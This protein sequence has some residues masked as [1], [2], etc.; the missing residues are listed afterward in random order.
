MSFIIFRRE[1][2]GLL[3]DIAATSVE[4]ALE[5]YQKMHRPPFAAHFYAHD[6]FSVSRP[7]MQDYRI[8]LTMQ[9]SLSEVL[10]LELAER[11]LYDNV[12]MQFCMH[13]AF[14]TASKARMM[15][16]NVSRYL[17]RG[18]VFIGTIPDSSLLLWVHIFFC[19]ATVANYQGE[20]GRST[21]R[22]SFFAIWKRLLLCPVRREVS[23]RCIRTSI[24]VLPRRCDRRR[25]GVPCRLGQLRRVSRLR[26]SISGGHC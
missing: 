19:E 9:R 6:C 15:I 17:R 1:G 14:E 25:P 12:T 10:P 18:G 26:I 13:Y 22:F 2:C 20:I 11:D 3:S 8:R 21:G 4:Q 23:S 16:E 5:R 7:H 24:F